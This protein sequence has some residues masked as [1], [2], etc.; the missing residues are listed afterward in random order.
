MKVEKAKYEGWQFSAEEKHMEKA[1][2]VFEK[3]ATKF[4]QEAPD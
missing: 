3:G 2:R 1:E 4:M